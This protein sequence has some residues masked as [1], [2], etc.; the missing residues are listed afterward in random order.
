MKPHRQRG[1][2][3]VEIAIVLVVIGLLLGGILR[4][5]QLIASARV[6]N[7]ADQNS[8][9]QAAYFG[10][11]DRFR[12]IP[13]DMPEWRACK[14][15]TTDVSAGCPGSN[16]GAGGI[17]GDQNGRVDT[18]QEAGALWAHL[19]HA[20]FLAGSYRGDTANAAAYE[21]GVLQNQV[22]GNAFQQP[23]LLGYTDGYETAS[24]AVPGST[25]A[26]PTARLAYVF[27]S[28]VPAA[29]LRELDVKLDDG[30]PSTGVVRA[31]T[32]SGAPGDNSAGGGTADFAASD[33][34]Q[35][36]A[37]CVSE[38]NSSDASW[39]VDSDAI[40]CNAVYLY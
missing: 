31:T 24:T 16:T 25:P 38:R 40:N 2:T 9:V 13:G 11:I 18:W 26:A 35:S 36:D 6:R 23:I 28:A 37:S 20:K 22:P 39:N 14:A 15:I 27:G 21:A 12:Q 17:G 33:V 8:G 19:S 3:L 5:Q 30:M 29:L 1:F 10:F 32:S 34:V 7:L 4:G